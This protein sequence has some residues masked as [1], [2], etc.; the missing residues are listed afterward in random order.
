[1]V[2]LQIINIIQESLTE[3]KKKKK[4]THAGAI[5][6]KSIKNS[7]SPDIQKIVEIP[8]DPEIV[9]IKDE[10]DKDPP[11]EEE[12]SAVNG[13]AQ[14]EHEP[15]DENAD[16]VYVEDTDV[17]NEILEEREETVEQEEVV[18]I[19]DADGKRKCS[20][21]CPLIISKED[22]MEEGPHSCPICSTIVLPCDHLLK[23]HMRLVHGW[24]KSKRT[25]F[26]QSKL[27]CF[28]CSC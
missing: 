18:N 16:S 3:D 8:K 19:W 10:E 11:T 14:A 22:Y 20:I 24:F 7:K 17:D 23:D 26:K 27:L 13:G 6:K 21:Y 9:E 4:K 1:M 5:G 28:H 25:F 15:A 2:F 12:N